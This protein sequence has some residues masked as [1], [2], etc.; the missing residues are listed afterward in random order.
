MG[1]CY[2]SIDWSRVV[3]GLNEKECRADSALIGRATALSAASS[4]V[5]EFL[6]GRPAE[7]V[8]RGD[9]AAEAS[10]EPRAALQ[11]MAMLEAIRTSRVNCLDRSF[12]I[13]PGPH[14]LSQTVAT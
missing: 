2:A 10:L 14:G 12:S 6:P 11:E 1:G 3:A 4:G 13:A 7:V 5:Q 8:R 9:L